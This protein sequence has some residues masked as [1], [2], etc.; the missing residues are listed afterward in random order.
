VN[1]IRAL[2]LVGVGA[3]LAACGGQ[4][5]PTSSSDAPTTTMPSASSTP[6]AEPSSS[7]VATAGPE[8]D[9]AQILT[10]SRE[11]MKTLRSVRIIGWL[12]M[13]GGAKLVMNIRLSRAGPCVGLVEYDGDPMEVIKTGDDFWLRAD[14]RFWIRS[15]ASRDVAA[16]FSDK[17]VHGDAGEM[18]APCDLEKMMGSVYGDTAPPAPG[19]VPPPRPGV[20]D[21]QRVLWFDGK[22]DGEFT[23][24]SVLA[25]SPHYVL[26]S[27]SNEA[28][29]NFSHINEPV[30]ATPPPADEV[31]EA[32]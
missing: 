8:R 29:I 11:A 10:S 7:P 27:R 24:T 30:E 5:T 13:E 17:W 15:G 31:V 3:L 20:V 19:S 21:G 14:A 4:A 16:T 25:K 28:D 9:G 18:P 32:G 6:T 22:V 26:R 2:G 23:Q 1:L 12:K